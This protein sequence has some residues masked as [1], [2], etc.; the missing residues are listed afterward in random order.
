MGGEEEAVLVAGEILEKMGSY[1]VENGGEASN[2]QTLDTGRG[3]GR[4]RGREG[5]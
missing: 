1:L 4:G 2:Y 3:R 5:Y